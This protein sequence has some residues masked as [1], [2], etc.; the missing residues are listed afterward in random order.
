MS[1]A[2]TALSLGRFGVVLLPEGALQ[3]GHLEKVAPGKFR[4]VLWPKG[5]T[6]ERLKSRPL[7]NRS[8]KMSYFLL[9]GLTCMSSETCRDTCLLMHP[10]SSME[11]K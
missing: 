8:L 6:L 9:I 11:A 10:D 3:I 2:P 7:Q 1:A 5:H 4:V